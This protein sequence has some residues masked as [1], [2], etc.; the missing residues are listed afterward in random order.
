[1][2]VPRRRPARRIP[3]HPSVLDQDG[4]RL[5]VSDS[6]GIA[7]ADLLGE[8][9]K[10][11]LQLPEVGGVPIAST[12]GEELG[13]R[14][15]DSAPFSS[16][17][18]DL[19]LWTAPGY[20]LEPSAATKFLRSLPL[21]RESDRSFTDAG[22]SD[23]EL[24]PDI[25][26]AAHAIEMVVE[27]VARGRLLPDLEFVAGHWRACWRPL[28]EGHDR[29]R[30]EALAWALPASFD[31]GARARVEHRRLVGQLGP[32][33]S[34]EVLR[35]LMW[36]VT[37]ALARDLITPCHAEGPETGYQSERRR[38]LAACSRFTRRPPR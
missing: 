25:R 29:G 28:I 38:C 27:L 6:A 35:S 23:V 3:P 16:S 7:A 20:V 36:A 32:E 30:I 5:A 10:L 18:E 4:L 22:P 31:S 14:I 12:L 17:W 33:P 24:G 21:L 11:T 13:D 15:P 9:V 34:D 8:D 1:M 37:D 26:F 19:S 2:P